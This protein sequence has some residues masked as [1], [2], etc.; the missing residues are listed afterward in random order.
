MT[1]HAFT[2]PNI[3]DLTE[4][5]R[6][7]QSGKLQE[8][9]AL[10]QRGFSERTPASRTDGQ[11]SPT[12]DLVADETGTFRAQ[13]TRPEPMDADTHAAILPKGLREGLGQVLKGLRGLAPLSKG[14]GGFDL[15]GTQPERRGP[16]DPRF[17][18]R[19]FSNAAG[20]RDY[21]LFIPTGQTG[22][23]PLVVM[24][25]GC[26]QSPDDFAAGTRMNELAQQDGIYVA[27]PRQIQ[28]ANAQK[29]WNWFQP[30]DQGRERGESG[31]IAGLTRAILAEHPIDPSRVYIAGLSAG[32]AKA[33]NVARAYPDLF[34]GVGVHSGLA[35]GCARDL[36]SALMAMRAGAPGAEQPGGGSGFGTG[37]ASDAVRVPTIVFHGA[38]DATVNPKNG[39]EVLAQAGIAGLSPRR[40]SGTQPGGHRYARTRY[41]DGQ[42]RVQV[43]SWR[44]DGAG[45]AWSGGSKTSSYTDPLGPDASRAMLDFF[46]EHRLGALRH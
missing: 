8:A 18:E 16:S 13:A 12:I 19:S 46:A 25:H 27:Y 38:N 24:L 33:V 7:T 31:I 10:L 6:L 21:K 17:V 3:S 28:G 26:T 20:T 9:T 37:Q 15:P 35:A 39:D 2:M 22:P 34:A 23:R 40:E 1:D 29:C 42:G 30:N 41:A 4:A 5:A 43:E 44:I 45:H 14:L 32:G 11:T 36:P